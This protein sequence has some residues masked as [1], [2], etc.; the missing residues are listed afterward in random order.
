MSISCGDEL[1]FMS[2]DPL[3]LQDAFDQLMEYATQDSDPGLF[4]PYRKP[5]AAGVVAFRERLLAVEPQQLDRLVDIAAQAYRRP[6]A[7]QE[8]DEL[9]GLYRKLRSEDLSH[10]EAFHVVLAPRFCFTCLSLS[11]R[12]C[13]PGS[14]PLPVSSWEMASRVELFPVVVLPGRSIAQSR[15]R[16][17]LQ[18][19]GILVA[20][21]RR[22]FAGE[23]R[24]QPGDRVRLPLA[25][26]ARLRQAR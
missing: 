25:G 3:R 22:M 26:R 7:P 4:E 5:I 14:E 21:A 23:A 11:G 17:E 10:E 24:S 8:A 12:K 9:R 20:E 2:Q 15:G 1:R 16:R 18:D 6:L 13:R 19:V